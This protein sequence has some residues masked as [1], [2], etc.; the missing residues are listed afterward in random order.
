[1]T[2]LLVEGMGSIKDIVAELN[3]IRRDH[4]MLSKEEILFLQRLGDLFDQV[5]DEIRFVIRNNTRH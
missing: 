5:S 1:M 4:V 2:Y 3:R